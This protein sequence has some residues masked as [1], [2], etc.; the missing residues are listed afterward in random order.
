MQTPGDKNGGFYVDKWFLDAVGDQGEAMIFYVA[1]LTWHGWTVPYTSWLRYDPKAGLR[2]KSRFRN[3]RMPEKSEAGLVWEDPQFGIKGC[4][5]ALAQ[6]LQARIFESDEGYLDW[7][8]H[9]PASKVRIESKEGG[10][11]EGRGYVEQLRMTLPP[12]QV[13]MQELRWGRFGSEAD[14]VVWIEI[15]E[16]VKRQWL[17]LNGVPV[18]SGSIEDDRIAAPEAGWLLTLDRNTVLESEKKIF[19]VVGG[20][21][22]YLPGLNKVMPL[23]FL[24][25]DNCKWLSKGQLQ[26]AGKAAAAGVA[27][28]ERVD[29]K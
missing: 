19:S 4:W 23:S 9:Q 24:M 27:I 1:T 21:L 2:Q 8:C 20:L 29:F 25:A 7:H 12:W 17:W 11:W 28:H 15:R 18:P 3:I 16:A 5:E 13:P 26:Q 22:R 14:G 10:V 6:P